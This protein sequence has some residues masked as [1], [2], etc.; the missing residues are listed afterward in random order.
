MQYETITQI[1]RNRKKDKAGNRSEQQD[2]IIITP[3]EIPNILEMDDFSNLIESDA[4]KMLNKK[5][6]INQKARQDATV[7]FSNDV[8]S[9]LQ[10]DEMSSLLESKTKYSFEENDL[11]LTENGHLKSVEV[12]G[13][14]ESVDV[15]DISEEEEEI[16][17]MIPYED[18]VMFKVF[19]EEIEKFFKDETLQSSLERK[20]L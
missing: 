8:A 19:T 11:T 20:Y 3:E 2:D 14:A 12:S 16:V 4:N 18:T 7:I 9:Y 17:E 10:T 6:M 5:Q 13:H 1:V 15:V